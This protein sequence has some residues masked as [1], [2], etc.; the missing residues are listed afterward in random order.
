MSSEF[1]FDVFLNHSHEDRA[2]VRSLAKRLRRDELHVWFDEWG[3]KPGDSI[4]AKT[5][6]GIEHSRVLMLCLSASGFGYGWEWWATRPVFSDQLNTGRRLIPL[7]V[8]DSP[9]PEELRQLA[10]VDR[11]RKSDDQYA[12]L[13]AACRSALEGSSTRI[14]RSPWPAGRTEFFGVQVL[15]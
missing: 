12:A 11:R 7:R 14:V 13:L 6:E 15:R 1:Q 9:S 4:S 3:I 2:S 8:D 10:Y 5:E